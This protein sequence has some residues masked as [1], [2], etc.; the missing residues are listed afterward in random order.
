MILKDMDGMPTIICQVNEFLVV[1][2]KQNTQFLTY[3]STEFNPSDNRFKATKFKV[4]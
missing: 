3:K 2:M 1:D 4:F